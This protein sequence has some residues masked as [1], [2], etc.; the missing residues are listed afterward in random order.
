MQLVANRTVGIRSSK[1]AR[2][3]GCLSIEALDRRVTA[4]DQPLLVQLL[5][6]DVRQSV[7]RICQ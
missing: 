1:D 6:R 5:V 2:I 4:A 3:T 7:G